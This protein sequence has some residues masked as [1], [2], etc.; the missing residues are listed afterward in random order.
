MPQHT[1]HGPWLLVA[2]MLAGIAVALAGAAL[3]SRGSAS[4]SLPWDDV[5]LLTEV[6]ERVKQEYVESVD[7]HQLMENAVRGIVTALD[8]HSEFLDAEAF[9]EIRISTS[10]NYS[11]VGLE[12]GL[13]NGQ[14]VVV[15]PIEGTPADRAGIRSGDI[16]VA[17][18]GV[19]VAE[20]DIGGA[21]SRLRGE[22]G[23]PVNV[24]VSRSGDARTRSFDLVRSNVRVHS[25]RVELLEPGY[26]YLR[27]SQ[28][29]DSTGSDVRKALGELRD[30]PGGAALYGLVLDLRNNPG[31]VL[32]A[33]VDVS[34]EFLASGV[35]VTASGRGSEA[36]FRHEATTGDLMQGAPMV[37]LVNNG[38]ASAAE[39]VAGALKDNQR[40]TIMGSQTFGKGS[41][42]TVM[43][44]SDGRAIKLTTSRYYTPSGLSINGEGITPDVLLDEQST[45]SDSRAT[46]DDPAVVQALGLL[47]VELAATAQSH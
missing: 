26:A 9:E 12:V 24:T 47:K 32:E 13:R 30:R 11:G 25:V 36:N 39:I 7:D 5:R 27:I 4:D 44:L 41:V 23:T 19:L 42:Q 14:L 17:I 3:A 33:A 16:I 2:G 21:L 20:G 1:R 28:F 46:V 15:T 29:S 31:G 35:I 22:P 18:D 37:V 45:N 38:S 34:D 40:A 6:L 43:P 10:G 8:P